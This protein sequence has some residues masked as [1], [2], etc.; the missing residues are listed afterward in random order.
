MLVVLYNDAIKIQNMKETIMMKKI[1]VLALVFATSF[2][3]AM[4]VKEVNKASKDELMK[5]NG[6]GEKKADAIIKHRKKAAFKS[7]EDLEQVKGVGPALVKNIKNDVYKKTT[8]KKS[9]T[10]TKSTKS[11]KSKKTTATSSK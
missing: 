3:F 10:A 9:T 7:L 4:S 8:S 6:I 1:V 2:A 5:I 11:D